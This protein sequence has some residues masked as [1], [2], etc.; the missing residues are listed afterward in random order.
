MAVNPDALLVL[1]IEFGE[2]RG[3]NGAH[4]VGPVA[5]NDGLDRRGMMRHHDKPFQGSPRT[6]NRL[7]LGTI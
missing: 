3:E 6:G 1:Q 2:L 5:I 4:R 7:T